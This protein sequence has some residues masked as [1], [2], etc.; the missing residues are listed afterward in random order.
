MSNVKPNGDNGTSGFVECSWTT[1][2]N[3][4]LH[5]V[6]VF[7][8][9]HLRMIAP[10]LTAQLKG[11]ADQRNRCFGEAIANA[12]ERLG[13]VF[14]KAAQ[15]LSYRSDLFPASL[16]TPIARLQEQ[17]APLPRGAARRV[18]ERALGAPT[19]SLFDD[20][21]DEPV[22]CGS[23]ATVHR[24][25]TRGGEV[26]AVKIVRPG[27]KERIDIDL[28]C[29]HAIVARLAR[30]RFAAGMPVRE[31]FGGIAHMISDQ[32]NMIEE[33]RNLHALRQSA[34]AVSGV[35]IPRA[36]TE[37]ALTR[38]LLVMDFI[39]GSVPITAV[40]LPEDA[41]KAAARKILQVV[42][43]M[44]FVDRLVHGD[45]HPGNVHASAG[46]TAYLFD[47]GLA[48][49]LTVEDS[50]C[51]RDFFVALAMGNADA[52]AN[53]IIRSAANIPLDF[54][55]TA[56]DAEV[57]VLVRAYTGRT[58]GS[59]LVVEF[60]YQIFALQRKHR[61][62]GAPGFVTAIWALIMFEGIVRGR[63]PELD[64]Q[65][66]ARPFALVSMLRTSATVPPGHRVAGVRVDDTSPYGHDQTQPT[67]FRAAE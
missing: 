66:T 47:A 41:F 36:R 57:A 17:V 8:L 3:R 30:T 19:T 51:F 6:G 1:V 56:F 14:V 55:R 10:A 35:T 43:R 25:T 44:I 49:T 24:A 37:I 61:L 13:P 48:A 11:D 9:M 50:D 42:Y 5:I 7:L 38:D 40:D 21:E 20:F 18:V 32:A 58:A 26:I 28:A 39:S 29:L 33:A 53:A 67:A 60:V 54:Q 63:Y 52:V 16:L 59:F 12:A 27:I 2:C 45:L 62:Y 64:F 65:A 22:A 31:I 46:G 4:L 23:I 34:V 15:M